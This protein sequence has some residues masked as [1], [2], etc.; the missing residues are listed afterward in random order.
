MS[1]WEL[2]KEIEVKEVTPVLGMDFWR[3]EGVWVDYYELTS[4]NDDDQ[5]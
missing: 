2:Q 5:I 3:M 4:E 1:L